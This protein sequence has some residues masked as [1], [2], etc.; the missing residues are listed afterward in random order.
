MKFTGIREHFFSVCVYL[1]LCLH[2]PGCVLA[3]MCVCVYVC[4]CVCVWCVCACV[5]VCM[6]VC[7]LQRHRQVNTALEEEFSNGLYALAIEVSIQTVAT[8]C[9]AV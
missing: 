2:V 3:C 6:C 8:T 7:V 1:C 5:C 9:V 4:V